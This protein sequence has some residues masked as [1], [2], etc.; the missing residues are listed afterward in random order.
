[1]SV[2]Y[3]DCFSGISGNM[4]VGAL[5][6]AGMPMGYLETE[7]KKLP[8]SSYKLIDKEVTKKGIRARYF[9][10]E[11]R[12]WFQPSRNF[13]DIRNI[14]EKSTLSDQVKQCSS[15]IF[16][17][18]AAAEAKVHGVPV[19]K[20]HFH[21]VGAVDSIIDIVG[22]AI[23]LEYLGIKEIYASALHVG[24]G[25]VKCSHGQMPV[26]AP[27]TAELLSGIPFYAE[28]IKKELVT[29]TGAAIVATLVKGFGSTPPNFKSRKVCYG[30]GSRDIEIPNVLRLYLGEKNYAAETGNAG[31]TKIVETNIDDLNPQVYG[32]VMERLF[33]AGAHDVYLTSI[34]MKKNRP[35]TKITVMVSPEKV[36]DIVQI[37]LAETSTL[38]VRI[39]G[40]E[41]AHVDVS[42]INVDTEWGTVKVKVG[43]L[44]DRLI[45]VAPE[46]EDCKTIAA[47]HKIPLKTIH[48]HVL[49]NC[50]PMLD[51]MAK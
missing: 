4:M 20:I 35:G 5:L 46:F 34:I 13:T 26:P 29:P 50:G 36:N 32:Y 24:A 40:C 47:R 2:A 30:A 28:N 51:L 7:L 22:T 37:M 10:V 3:L 39:L 12:K 49:R 45:N 31:E 33:A 14:I 25:Y 1:M 18:L 8:L 41:T 38:G 17:K 43:K 44:N 48:L 23:G 19:E 15:A 6:D 16:S 9:N 27:A 11:V 42:M 21:E